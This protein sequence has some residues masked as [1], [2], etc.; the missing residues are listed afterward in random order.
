MSMRVS[1]SLRSAAECGREGIIPWQR[2]YLVDICG[3]PILVYRRLGR[4]G[5][6]LVVF[7]PG[8]GHL[9]RVAYGHPG[10]RP[11][12]FLDH[13]LEEL[14]WGLLAPS[15]PG[16]QSAGNRDLAGL[17]LS[18]WTEAVGDVVSTAVQLRSSPIVALGWSM[19]G[20]SAPV[21]ADA[22]RA[23]DIPLVFF[24][25]VAASPPIRGLSSVCPATEVFRSDGFWDPQASPVDGTTRQALWLKDL[26]EISAQLGR[27]PITPAAYRAH[28][29]SAT[30]YRL[31]VEADLRPPQSVAQP[32]DTRPP[33]WASF[34]LLAPISPADPTDA[35]HALADAATWGFVTVQALLRS[36]V[37]PAFQAGLQLG[38]SDWSH[39]V[40]LFA[41]V[42]KRLHRHVPGNH[43][44]FVGET[45]ARA[46]SRALSD[47]ANEA[48]AVL[49][50][51]GELV[52]APVEVPPQKLHRR[53]PCA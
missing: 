41:C 23:R 34:P 39:L 28:Y 27:E 16:G 22:L 11:Q 51:L 1:R 53:A 36:R 19:G 26:A 52:P 9:A 32:E 20:R 49:R 29:I 14:G 30:P 10:S 48:A 24:A 50:E 40:E 45:G 33:A 2:E 42:P 13:W 18:E 46:V 38:S 35:R 47:L 31:M 25:P 37:L 17:S 21:L 44:C 15:Y 6:P 8:A 12:D 5:E 7:L 43:F 3:I 4:P